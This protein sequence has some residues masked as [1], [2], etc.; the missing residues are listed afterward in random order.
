MP[1]G[2]SPEHGPDEDGVSYSQEIVWDL[3]DN[4][5][6]AADALDADSAFRDTIAGL[7]DRLVTPKVGK[8]G[9]LQEWMTDRD[10]PND[11]HRHTSH[12]FA[13]YP[14]HQISPSRTPELARAA[15]VSLAARGETGDSRRSWTWPW[16]C[17][18]WARLGD[19]EKAHH[20]IRGLLTYNTRPNLFANHPPF[21]MD[22]NFG[23]TA[24]VCEMLVQSQAGEVAL[25]PALPQA[26][27]DGGVK[28]LRARGGF[29][30]DLAWKQGRL[31]S[32]AIHSSL[33]GPCAVRYGDQTATLQTRPGQTAVLDERLTP[34]P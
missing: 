1:D 28:G 14:G 34:T 12:L 23:I 26:W 33:G 5:V 18:L 19:P 27:S 9:Q 13:V 10:D 7:R 17:A 15:A 21:Q 11:H 4:T 22:G 20:M 29:T 30:V 6:A 2:W 32:A 8:W 31:T 24:A 25:L 16:R 3:F